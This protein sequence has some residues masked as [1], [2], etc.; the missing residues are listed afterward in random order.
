MDGRKDGWMGGWIGGVMDEMKGVRVHT[1][2][3]GRGHTFT[4]AGVQWGRQDEGNFSSSLV[5]QKA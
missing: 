4:F 3:G 2:I 5:L 1:Y